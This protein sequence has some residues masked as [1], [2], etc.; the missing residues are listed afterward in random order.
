[1]TLL[2]PERLFHLRAFRQARVGLL[3]DAEAYLPV[4]VCLENLGRRLHEGGNAAPPFV[5]GLVEP[6]VDFLAPFAY[7]FLSA[8]DS[9]NHVESLLKRLAHARNDAVHSGAYA[10][11]LG[12]GCLAVSLIAEEALSKNMN[13]VSD[14]MAGDVAVAEGW[15]P[16]SFARQIMLKNSFTWLPVYFD[17]KWQ[18]LS[19]QAVLK[20]LGQSQGNERARVLNTSIDELMSSGNLELCPATKIK[21]H[22]SADAARK[23]LSDNS[24]PLLVIDAAGHLVGI[25][26]AFDLL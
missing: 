25:V 5:N 11:H 20:A 26:M 1:M 4:F 12:T 2:A 9:K 8:S 21:N 17:K 23:I 13:T 22:E 15:Q 19:A 16:L 7:V 18:L 24:E 6:L 10:R 14:F 3:D